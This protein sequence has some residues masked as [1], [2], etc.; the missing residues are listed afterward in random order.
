MNRYLKRLIPIFIV[1]LLVLFIIR[2]GIQWQDFKIVVAQAGWGWL[3][4][5]IVF[6]VGSYS[7]IA[8]LNAILLRHYG[9][10]ISWRRQFF[11][12][13][14]MAFIEAAL[15]SA[16]ISGVL[17]RARLL[18]PYNV[19]F[20]V[21]VVTTVAETSMIVV[22]VILMLLPIIV[23]SL[24]QNAQIPWIMTIVLILS[25]IVIGTM[26]R[27]GNLRLSVSNFKFIRWFCRFWDRSIRARWPQKMEKWPGYRV[28]HQTHYFGSQF[29]TLLRARPYEISVS[30]M[31]RAGFEVLGLMMCYYALG[32]KLPF[33][34]TL[35]LYALTLIINTLGAIPGGI[36]FAEVALAALYAQF[37][38]SAVLA[39]SVAVLYRLT[40]YWLPRAAGGVAW[41]WMEHET[42]GHLLNAK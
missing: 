12:Q 40:G 38:I 16:A 22:S 26:K 33:S 20:D 41:F 18:K 1:F 9:A 6:Q 11:I 8:W 37:G 27:P 2:Q 35:W 31:A 14:A 7:A 23:L 4:L 17:L 28:I 32:I 39:I 42:P 25:L 29:F 15:P 30:L 3:V 21:A 34:T 13:L 24:F 19:S 36:G 5:A 10:G